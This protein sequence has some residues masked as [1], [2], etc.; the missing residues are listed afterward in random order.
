MA[1]W[2][3]EGSCPATD[4]ELADLD[5]IA[6]LKEASAIEYKVYFSSLE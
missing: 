3:E 1:L 4:Q 2:M 5:A 6:A